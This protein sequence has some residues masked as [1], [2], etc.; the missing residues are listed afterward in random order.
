MAIGFLTKVG[1]GIT[2]LAGKSG[3]IL[4][5][6]SP[7]LL[8]VGGVIGVVGAAVMA[9]RAT[10]KVEEVLE[11]AE[12]KFDKIKN[13][14]GTEQMSVE[15]YKKSYYGKD[16]MTAYIQTG[17]DFVKLYGPWVAVGAASISLIITG[18][19]ILKRRNFALMAAY[20]TLDEG[21]KAYQRRVAAK[22]GVE[23]EYNLRHGISKCE[24]TEMGY[25]DENGVEHPPVVSTATVAP[26]DASIYA[27]Y[28]KQRREYG[29]GG[30]LHWSPIQGHN[31]MNLKAAQT[32]FNNQLQ[33]MGHVFLNE[34]YDALGYERTSYGQAVG[35]VL[36]GDGDGFIDFGMNSA[37][38]A[39]FMNDETQ[40]CLLDFNVDGVVFDRI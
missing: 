6:R 37:Y 5:M 32:S 3:L 14:A 21:F 39:G 20:K 22:Y 19:I 35:W 7:E 34:V 11:K 38:N 13:F 28:Y 29:D 26:Y 27:R 25:T 4:K 10:L 24:L 1:T 2:K 15:E 30:T 16:I 36:K 33:Q 8:L 12:E 17:W 40:D 18:H 31:R 23:E 9:C